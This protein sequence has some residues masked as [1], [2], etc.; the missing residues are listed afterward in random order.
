MLHGDLHHGNVLD[1][2]DEG[3]LAIDPKGIVGERAF[4]YAALFANPDL[5]DS[6]QPVATDPGRFARRLEVVAAVGSLDRE[7]LLRWVFAWCGLSATWSLA[8]GETAEI[9]L[10]IA[11][12]AR[13][14]LDQ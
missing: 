8:D 1:F 9:A 7:R 3:W 6:V 12:L 14:E 11:E 10:R 4:D 13:A 2:G 5:A